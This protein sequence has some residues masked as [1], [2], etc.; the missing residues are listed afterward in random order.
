[1]TP[2][3]MPKFLKNI[4]CK[5]KRPYSPPPAID[6]LR[7]FFIYCDGLEAHV[8]IQS[9]NSGGQFQTNF[10][11]YPTTPAQNT[12]FDEV[13]LESI[14][15][16]IRQ[17]LFPKELFYYK[18]LRKAYIEIF[19]EDTALKTFYQNLSRV[20]NEPYP[21]TNVQMPRSN[22]RDLITGYT[23]SELIEARLYTGAIHSER[24]LI[25]APGSS[26]DGLVN[27]HQIL[28]LHLSLE[29]AA[30]SL[31]ACHNIF[32]FRWLILLAARQS[33]QIN[34]FPELAALETRARQAGF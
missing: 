18:D 26:T 25:S 6:R 13:H 27:M 14:L 5:K 2:L 7:E 4:F 1:M 12:N 22:G 10:A 9:H 3:K 23:F 33:N 16:R 17:F 28:S 11:S 21:P 34:L 32:A 15:L 30:G 19:S 8:F 24:R 20:I 29:L 31:I